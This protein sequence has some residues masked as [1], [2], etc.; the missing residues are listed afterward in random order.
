MTTQVPKEGSDFTVYKVGNA[1][2]NQAKVI[3]AFDMS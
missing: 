2:K 1:L 3:E